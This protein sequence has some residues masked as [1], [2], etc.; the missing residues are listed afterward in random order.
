MARLRL[1]GMRMRPIGAPI[2]VQPTPGQP[3]YAKFAPPPLP[4][5]KLSDTKTRMNTYFTKPGETSLLY[6]AEG[7]VFVRLTLEDA[8]PVSVGMDQNITPV[9]SGRGV[10][11]PTN[12]ERHFTMTKGDR[13]FIAAEA[14]NRVS[15]TIEPM[16]ISAILGA[17]MSLGKGL[18]GK[19]L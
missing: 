19:V 5:V 4:T 8:G 17:I 11:L 12:I 1:P 15:F 3:N 10:L 2:V 6:S 16:G 13:I 14:I 18:L 7:W 9:L